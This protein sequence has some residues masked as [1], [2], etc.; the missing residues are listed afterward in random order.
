MSWAGICN[1]LGIALGILY[2]AG[3]MYSPNCTDKWLECF[4]EKPRTVSEWTGLS[5]KAKSVKRF[6]RSNGLDTALYKN[7]LY[8]FFFSHR[9]I[10]CDGIMSW[11][12]IMSLGEMTPVQHMHKLDKTID[13]LISRQIIIAKMHTH[14]YYIHHPK[15][16]LLTAFRWWFVVGFR[17][18]V[19]PSRKYVKHTK[20][21]NILSVIFGWF[22]AI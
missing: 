1:A 21:C 9:I 8:T 7:Y 12:G 5:G 13:Y 20:C 10:S 6:E 19:I 17:V 22:H 14:P 16:C 4:P 11:A 18:S 3:I 2:C 15:S